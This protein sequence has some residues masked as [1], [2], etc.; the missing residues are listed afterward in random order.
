MKYFPDLRGLINHLQINL[1]ADKTLEP[2]LLNL[3]TLK[4]KPLMQA[5]RDKAFDRMYQWV[6]ECNETELSSVYSSL[7]NVFLPMETNKYTDLQG[8]M[9]AVLLIDRYQERSELV[10]DPHITLV[11]CLTELMTNLEG[12]YKSF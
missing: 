5:L 1:T 11:A 8:A 12:R 7:Y 6:V 10:K 3:S 4:M 9:L 2:S